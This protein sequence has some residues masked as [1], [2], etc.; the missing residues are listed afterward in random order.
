MHKPLIA[1]LLTL[2]RL[3]FMAKEHKQP[4]EENKKDSVSVPGG[5]EPD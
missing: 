4:E 5:D 1:K 3:I 2:V